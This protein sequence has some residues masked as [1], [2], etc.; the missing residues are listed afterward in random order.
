VNKKNILPIIAIVV[1]LACLILAVRHAIHFESPIV[2][3]V[4]G[5]DW[6]LYF[7]PATMEVLHGRTPYAIEGFY[8]PPWVTIP[9]LPLATL[10]LDWSIPIMMTLNLAAWTYTAMRLGMKSFI[11]L[12]FIIFSGAMINSTIGNLD[13]LL[14]LGLFLP[15]PLAVL[16]VMIKPQIG[17]PI[18][19]FWSMRILLDRGTLKLKFI[20][21]AKLLAPFALLMVLSFVLYGTWFIQGADAVGK[22]WNTS[23]WPR[24]IPLGV[25]LLVLSIYTKDLRWA[26]AAIPYVTPYLSPDTWAFST[27]AILALASGIKINIPRL[28]PHP[29]LKNR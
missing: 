18:V 29:I 28:A 7:Q 4:I 16:V 13:G 25:S 5:A 8:N 22:S 1:F 6:R 11:I 20:N 9:L 26:L 21:M 3:S 23:P 2:A 17:A 14:S 10:P 27:L 12:P 24:L 19:L 15:P